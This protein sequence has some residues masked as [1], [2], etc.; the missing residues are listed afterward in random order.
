MAIKMDFLEER[1]KQMMMKQ[2]NVFRNQ[3]PW[4]GMLDEGAKQIVKMIKK[5]IT[6]A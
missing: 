2:F 5:E 3:V 4:D 6:N 1:T